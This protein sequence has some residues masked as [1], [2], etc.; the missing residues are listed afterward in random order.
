MV[1]YA[2]ETIENSKQV[3][4]GL[5]FSTK[6]LV[7]ISLAVSF[8]FFLRF[9]T[10]IIYLVARWRLLG[11]FIINGVLVIPVKGN[12]TPYSFFGLVFIP[13]HL[14]GDPSL[15]NILLHEKAHIKKLHSVDLVIV[16][17]LTIFFWFHPALWFLRHELKLQHEFAADRYVLGHNVDKIAYQQLLVNFSC[18]SYCLP[19]TN[20]FN[21]SP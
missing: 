11:G 12:Q 19:V 14:L 13:Q 9:A 2:S 15:N 3:F 17:V 1:I 6:E 8:L 5:I 16:E 4:Q 10:G 20:H 21:V 7:Y 18:I